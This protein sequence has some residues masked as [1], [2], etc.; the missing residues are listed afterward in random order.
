MIVLRVY[1][2][3]NLRLLYSA[4]IFKV[5]FAA[6]DLNFVDKN[7]VRSLRSRI[8]CKAYEVG[9]CAKPTK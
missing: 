3:F 4:L 1:Y 9:F 7:V 5:C 6:S 2:I 8:L